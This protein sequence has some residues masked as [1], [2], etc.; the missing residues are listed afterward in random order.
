[1]DVLIG[2]IVREAGKSLA[3]A[4]ADLNRETPPG[5]TPLMHAVDVEC[6]APVQRGVPTEGIPLS[7]IELLLSLG[8]QPT[9][10][11]FQ[12]AEKYRNHRAIA[13][14]RVSLGEPPATCR[15]R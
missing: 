13:T 11:A 6:D 4:G 14:L 5:W 7:L 2:L 10:E 9:A 12:I 3:N 1:M 15:Y 8:A